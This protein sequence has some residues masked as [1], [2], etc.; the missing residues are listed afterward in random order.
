MFDIKNQRLQHIYNEEKDELEK[1]FMEVHKIFDSRTFKYEVLISFWLCIH[2]ERL[3]LA[4]LIHQQDPIL[5]KI[6]QNLRRSARE[7][8]RKGTLL[9]PQQPA[10]GQGTG[11]NDS[12]SDKK[13]DL[14]AKGKKQLTK[15]EPEVKSG[16]GPKSQ[17]RSDFDA[18]LYG[19]NS[20]EELK[21]IKELLK[22]AVGQTFNTNVMRIA[23]NMQEERIASLLIAY[24]TVRVD[25]E[26]VLRAIKTAQL[27]FL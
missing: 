26:M 3:E 25:E 27:D 24:Y 5:E 17:G 7:S 6:L 22:T 1:N 2:M 9:L 4:Q 11:D 8:K 12:N 10:S 23:L 20:I 14:N 19:L 16:D 18:M 21:E 13:T 15:I